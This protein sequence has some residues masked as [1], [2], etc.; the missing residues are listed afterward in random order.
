MP[1]RHFFTAPDSLCLQ[2]ADYLIQGESEG[3][4][5]LST[6]L[7]ITPTAGAARQINESLKKAGLKPPAS[8]LPMQALLPKSD[9]TASSVE[10]SLA[11]S[12]ALQSSSPGE[13]QALFWRAS[14]ETSAELLKAGRKFCHLCDQ[15]AEAALSPKTIT[16]PSQLAGSF[17]EG[18]WQAIA[19]LYQGYLACLEGWELE[20]PNEQRLGQI[21]KPDTGFS[22]FVIAG[23][24]DLPVAA[25]RF[26]ESAERQDATVEVLVWNPG[27][28][29]ENSF[30]AWG[31]PNAEH[32]NHCALEVS[33]GQIKVCASARDEARLAKTSALETSS[34]DVAGLVV[35]DPK[36]QTALSGEIL[37]SGHRP[38]R[39]EGEPLIRG[40]AATLALEWEEF[41]AGKDL[42]RLRCLL[43][44][45]AFCRALDPENTLSQSEALTTID[46]LLGLTLATTL[47]VARAATAA[48]AEFKPAY[49]REELASIR[50]LLANVQSIL[51][52]SSLDL[53][54]RAFPKKSNRPE[55]VE[56]VLEIGRHLE[57]SAAVK[58]WSQRGPA[59]LPVQVFAQALRAEQIQSAAQ[60]DDIVLNGWLEAVWLPERRLH[61][62]GMVDGCLPQSVDGDPFLPDSI[63]PTLGLSHNKLRQAR[64]AY[65]LD[66]LLKSRTQE[67]LTLSFSKYNNEGD[68]N[69]PSRLLM[70]TALDVL[71]ER[72]K[73][74]LAPQATSRERAKR[75][76]DWRW[77][78]PEELPKVEKVSPTQFKS[79]LE[80]P[81]RF[82]LEKVL[83]LETGPSAAHEMDAAV[84]GNLIHRALES[85]GNRAIP[86]K[87]KMLQLDEATIHEWVQGELEKEAQRQF[88]PNPAPA[89]QVQLASAASRLNA[90]ARKQ[91]EC[92]A[93]GWIILQVEEKLEADSDK[94]LMIGPLALSGMIDRIEQHVESGAL[95]ILDYKT[96]SSLQKPSQTHFGPLSRN[97]FSDAKI[98]IAGK[99]RTWTDLQLPL[100]R[101][102]LEHWYPEETARHLPEV[103]YFVLPSD[104]NESG[105]Y[106]FAELNEADH[107]E[108]AIACAGKVAESIAA[109]V[110]W[111][112]Q[113]FR[114]SWDYPLAP[115]FVNGDSEHCISPDTIAKLKG[116]LA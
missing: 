97:W 47:D 14:P 69:R 20:D 67:E 104:P 86:L 94:P 66:C 71:P 75:Q 10:R 54:E 89:V 64:D 31:R 116:G 72:V 13:L 27:N 100:Y 11:W 77:R 6:T 63:R 114:G 3:R 68:P 12:E 24:A 9:T 103:A 51:K 78:L 91:A 101:R 21:E 73:H 2:V 109:G 55:T 45:P 83:K 42:R 70:R 99:P 36:L 19:S 15:L 30:D 82:C 32:W 39:P 85:F 62:S 92:F 111:P 105:I 41:R 58:N 112:P 95:R 90:F 25:S 60:V 98:E 29:P 88:G 74:V 57:D 102:I 79:Y 37:S 4:L 81:F 48:S 80:C 87:E 113:P 17:D 33:A 61:I 44:L 56:R 46:Q 76:T 16:L 108:H 28:A 96:F 106:R 49:R 50:R 26:A 5:K 34:P 8:V 1:K 40:E 43:E 110:F 93:E 35:A 107:Y 52:H 23:I 84:F 53:L 38:Y 18:R 59:A 22:H 115:L 65:L 7:V